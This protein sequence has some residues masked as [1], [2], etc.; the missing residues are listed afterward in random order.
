VPKAIHLSSS[1][2]AFDFPPSQSIPRSALLPSPF[3]P[4]F[5]ALPLFLASIESPTEFRVDFPGLSFPLLRLSQAEA[6]GVGFFIPCVKRMIHSHRPRRYTA[7]SFSPLPLLRP[8]QELSSFQ[9]VFPLLFP[10]T[11]IQ[12]YTPVLSSRLGSLLSQGS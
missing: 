5:T 12:I 3:P 10:E 8:P 4:P 6:G 9:L 11:P 1:F 2:L 7:P